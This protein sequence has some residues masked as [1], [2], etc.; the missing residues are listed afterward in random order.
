MTTSRE[1]LKE[2]IAKA[3]QTAITRQYV[4]GAGA[5]EE[6]SVG[7]GRLLSRLF[8]RFLPSMPC[9][10]LLSVPPANAL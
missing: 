10:S 3:R 4:G 8:P 9:Q 5:I 6:E 1:S 7:A 2:T